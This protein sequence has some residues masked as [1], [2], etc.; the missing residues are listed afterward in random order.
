MNNTTSDSF[1]EE[2]LEA[3]SSV[4]SAP[5]QPGVLFLKLRHTDNPIFSVTSQVEQIILYFFCQR[6]TLFTPP[7][8]PLKIKKKK[9]YKS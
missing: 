5:R 7:D 3:E 8:P 9:D 4:T 6:V 2:A 1:F